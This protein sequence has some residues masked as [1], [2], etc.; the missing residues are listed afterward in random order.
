MPLAEPAGGLPGNS[1]A[2]TGPGGASPAGDEADI[3]AEPSATIVK[4]LLLLRH[5]KATH[6]SRGGDVERPLAP[7]GIAAAE[8]LGRLLAAAGVLPDVLVT[9]PAERAR[10]TLQTVAAA[11]G[12]PLLAQL[13]RPLY[14]VGAR[15]VLDEVRQLPAGAGSALLVGHQPAWS[16]VAQ[17]LIG[18]G[19]LHVATCTLA[20]VRLDVETW[21]EVRPGS[22]ELLALLSPKLLPG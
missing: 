16:H 11:A 18:G 15:A 5:A 17:L 12:W 19:E 6:Q 10:Q 1:G 8:K 22:G 21:P 14:E 4:T 2:A 20:M 13:V 9:S 3:V 7:E